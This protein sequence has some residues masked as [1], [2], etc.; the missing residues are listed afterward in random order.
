MR[1]LPEAVDVQNNQR[2]WM[3]G[4]AIGSAALAAAGAFW[5]RSRSE[6]GASVPPDAELASFWA[7]PW[8]DPQG[9][10]LNVQQ[11]QG[12]P[13]LINFWATWCPP[14][15]EEL[16][17]INAFFQQNRANGW[18]VLGLAVDR[19]DMVQK[20]LRQNPVDFPVAM[21]GLGGSEL[22]R[23]L[24]N[25]SGGLPFTVVVGGNGTIAQRKLGRVS[26]ENLQQWAGLK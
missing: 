2:R 23:A 14:C 18:Q 10:S 13:L 16:P 26:S 25:V 1:E 22:G 7:T 17:L 6:D 15:V 19:V 20:F 12:K 9:K 3:V 11:F 21:A 8:T 5:W 24:G 4:A